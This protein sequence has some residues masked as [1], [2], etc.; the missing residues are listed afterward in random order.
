ML[1]QDIIQN[2]Y[3]EL[4][5]LDDKEHLQYLSGRPYVWGIGEEKFK[6]AAE[7]TSFFEEVLSDLHKR[8]LQSQ[9]NTQATQKK[10]KLEPA[11]AKLS[12]A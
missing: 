2:R 11:K 4:L 12:Q 7:Y 5:S 6:P 3:W 9:K 10:A 8:K 1:A